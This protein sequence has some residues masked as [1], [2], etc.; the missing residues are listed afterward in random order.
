MRTTT[1]LVLAASLCAAMPVIASAQLGTE[2]VRVEATV[3]AEPTTTVAPLPLN[4]RVNTHFTHD[5]QALMPKSSIARLAPAPD[6]GGKQTIVISTLAL[7][8]GIILIVV[9]V[10]R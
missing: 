8:L 4:S 6:E 10:A 2:P 5:T 7:V 3:V 1:S 9:L